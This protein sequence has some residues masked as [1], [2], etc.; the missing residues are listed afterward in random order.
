M[1]DRG[2]ARLEDLVALCPVLD[3]LGACGGTLAANL[4][5]DPL[6]SSRRARW[7]TTRVHTRRRA[8]WQRQAEAPP[9]FELQVGGLDVVQATDA[10]RWQAAGVDQVT[11]GARSQVQNLAR[12]ADAR[13]ARK[14]RCNFRHAKS[15]AH[16]FGGAENFCGADRD[17]RPAATGPR[18]RWSSRTEPVSLGV[19]TIGRVY[20]SDLALAISIMIALQLLG[21]LAIV[22]VMKS[23]T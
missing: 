22:Q 8:A 21:L 23:L 12:A 5:I 13:I 20:A 2:H 4:G 19:R 14:G 7:V 16:S 3:E 6:V 11:H 1:D 9:T 10:Q 17:D 15:I 18:D